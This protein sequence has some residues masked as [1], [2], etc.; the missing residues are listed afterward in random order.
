MNKNVYELLAA[1]RYQEAYDEASKY[2]EDDLVNRY[3]KERVQAHK[4]KRLQ[5]RRFN[6]FMGI[7]ASETDDT[8]DKKDKTPYDED[9][10]T[11][12]QIVVDE[13]F[14]SVGVKIDDLCN[15]KTDEIYD[16]IYNELD[17]GGVNKTNPF[18]QF[19]IIWLKRNGA[20]TL[21][22]DALKAISASFRRDTIDS[23]TL[24]GLGLEGKDNIIFI[25]DLY[26][27]S[28]AEY[29]ISE[30]M[31]YDV[32]NLSVALTNSKAA[33]SQIF[34]GR[35]RVDDTCVKRLRHLVIFESSGAKTATEAINIL[36]DKQFVTIN[37][38]DVSKVRSAQDVSAITAALRNILDVKAETKA[39]D[40]AKTSKS[41]AKTAVELDDSKF[42]NEKNAAAE[43]TKVLSNRYRL[44]D[45]KAIPNAQKQ[46]LRAY[47]DKALGLSND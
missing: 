39:A 13:F 16:F 14:A 7:D 9:E 11:D 15:V 12:K 2:Y 42:E 29:I 38:D 35:R 22:I 31:G 27:Q 44:K 25:P 19:Y 30:Y 18:V 24:S 4:F 34:L 47:L 46:A 33:L 6:K 8:D 23:K 40:K 20:I 17:W 45:I 26:R 36:N 1:K 37:V 21:T 43:L 5:A 32:H 28:N 3:E 41:N 10:R